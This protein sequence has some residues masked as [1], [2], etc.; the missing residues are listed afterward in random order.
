MTILKYVL[1]GIVGIIVVVGVVAAIFIAT[2]ED[3]FLGE[4]NAQC[5]TCHGEALEGTA[6][7]P[8]LVGRELTHG[9]SVAEIMQSITTG[10]PQRGMPAWGKSLDDGTVQRLAIFVAE[11][12]VD[13][14]FT[15]FKVYNELVIPEGDI[16]SERH[17]FHIET[18]ATDI[19]ALPFSLAPL[20]DGRFLVTEKTKGLRIV[21]AD[22][23]LSE[24]ITGTPQARDSTFE[25]G[26]LEYGVGWLMDVALH[27]DYEN[28]GWIYLHYGDLCES[29]DSF[30]PS[31]MNRVIRGRI[32][33]GAWV[34]DE[35]IW[36]TDHANY[37]P[38]PDM[39][40]G[41]RLCFDGE[42]ALFISI[43]MKGPSNYEGIQD[44]SLPYGKIHRVRDDGSIPTDNP[45]HGQPDV[46]PTTWTYGHRSPQGLEI[47]PV[48]GLLWSTEMGPRGGDELNLLKPGRNYG[49]PLYSKGVNYDGSPVN[50][51]V[52][53]G[54]E[55]DLEDIEQPVVDLTPSPAI[56]SFIFYDGASFPGW[57]HNI[58]AGSLK[59]TMLYRF[60]VEG[61]Q[62][63]HQEILLK[64]FGRIRDIE[65]GPDGN[66]YMLLEHSTGGRIVRMAPAAGD[67]IARR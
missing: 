33:E 6:L 22:G 27:P 14:L 17:T 23:T 10:F 40:A 15:D 38:T 60:V 52:Q 36:Q 51:G 20:P 1:L 4:Y 53:L 46:V 21:E 45:F 49:W 11:R 50:Y 61:E 24:Y 54:I 25:V 2:Y 12:R 48:T 59:A 31:T 18:V 32:H 26:Q 65:T 28:N 3:P 64:E 47:D 13:R 37:T 35:V 44:L 56:S 43:G 16:E 62:V 66:V 55:F 30:M 57:Q 63:V 42:G 39:A 34:D 41:G 9:D 5:A 29:C 8:A 58:L 67:A 7:G 19:D